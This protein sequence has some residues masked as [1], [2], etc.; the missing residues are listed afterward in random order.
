ME[1]KKTNEKMEK[2]IVLL[3]TTAKENYCYLND[4]GT[5]DNAN[6]IEEVGN[7]EGKGKREKKRESK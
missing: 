5:E 1:K 4:N 7:E 6:E 2:K 3:T